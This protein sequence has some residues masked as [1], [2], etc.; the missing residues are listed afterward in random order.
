MILTLFITQ[1]NQKD[2]SPLQ[3]DFLI[4]AV[5]LDE[6]TQWVKGP[7]SQTRVNDRQSM[8]I[9][10][11][12]RGK[13]RLVYQNFTYYKQSRTRSGFRWGC[14]KNRWHRC[15]AYLHLADD[16]TIVRS[17]ME[18][19]HIK[20]I[21]TVD[22]SEFLILHNYLYTK[23][24]EFSDGVSRYSCSSTSCNSYL[25]VNEDNMIVNA[26]IRHNHPFDKDVLLE[27]GL[28]EKDSNDAST[29]VNLGKARCITTVRGATVVIFDRYA[30]RFQSTMMNGL[31]RYPCS[32][33]GCLSYL[34]VDKKFMVTAAF[35]NHKH[36]PTKY[37]KMKD[38]RYESQ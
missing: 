7:V 13:E 22:G 12:A 9:F 28:Y 4:G 29:A 24:H 1:E 34:H 14:T 38:G 17:N 19:T 16:M 26:L 27:N 31:R 11:T 8:N 10:M 33:A 5:I 15:K 2:L 3:H 23:K 25:N 18:H 35:L 32:K 20:F 6:M 36:L 37:V 30:F 21:T